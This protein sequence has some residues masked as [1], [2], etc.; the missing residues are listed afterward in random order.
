MLS[1]SPMQCIISDGWR[2]LTAYFVSLGRMPLFGAQRVILSCET[3]Q[4]PQQGNALPMDFRMISASAK[5][6]F[7]KAGQ[8][9]L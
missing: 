4:H 7:E 8:Q 2:R 6:Y 3:L 9:P 1:G 5:P